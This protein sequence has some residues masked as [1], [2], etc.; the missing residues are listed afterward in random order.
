MTEKE[1][2]QILRKAR[3]ALI[4][5]NRSA[6]VRLTSEEI[7]DEIDIVRREMRDEK[8]LAR[9]NPPRR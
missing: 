9:R 7:Q 4:E 3:E 1:R 6:K 8:A 5:M 2:Q